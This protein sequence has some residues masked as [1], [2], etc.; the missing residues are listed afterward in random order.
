MALFI[1]DIYLSKIGDFMS[2]PRFK[3]KPSDLDYVENSFEIQVEIMNLCS[4]LSARWARIYQQPIDR[5]ATFQADFVNMASSIKITT[6]D[7]YVTRKWLL[8]MS[9]ACLHALEKRVMDMVRILYTN[10]SKCFNR[11]NGKNYTFSEAVNMLDKKL[12]ELGVK[13]QR[14]YDLIKGVMTADKKKYG[15]LVDGTISDKEIMSMLVS[16]GIQVFFE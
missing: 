7:D 15:S 5:L 6:V 12:E 11:K 1:F 4:K 10:P 13:Y 2:V 3:R 14:Q 9:N 16:K 8:K